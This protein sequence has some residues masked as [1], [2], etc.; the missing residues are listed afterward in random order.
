METEAVFDVDAEMTRYLVKLQ[1][2]MNRKAQMT[3]EGGQSIGTVP[4]QQRVSFENAQ[5]PRL[6]PQERNSYRG[7]PPVQSGN[8][9]TQSV[10]QS[11]SGD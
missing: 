10:E 7:I 11:A 8:H 9:S 5:P 1:R 3:V 4:Q 6:Q 2:L